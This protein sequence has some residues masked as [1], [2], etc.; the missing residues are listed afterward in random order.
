VGHVK[1]SSKTGIGSKRS[2][3]DER[4]TDTLLKL[5]VKDDK[6]NRSIVFRF[7]VHEFAEGY[8]LGREMTESI[9]NGGM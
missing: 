2:E 1:P 3:N 7:G 9:L 5:G 4:I 8:K 6:V